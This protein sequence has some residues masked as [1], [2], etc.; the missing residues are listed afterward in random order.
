RHYARLAFSLETKTRTKWGARL[1]WKGKI[2][3]RTR[4]NAATGKGECHST[5]RKGHSK[6]SS[7]HLQQSKPMR[8]QF[9]ENHREEFPVRRMCKVLAVS[10]GGYYAWRQRPV[11]ELK[12]ANEKLVEQIR[13]I[14][15]EFKGKYGSP[16]IHQELRDEKKI[17]CSENRVARLMRENGIQAVHKRR[18]RVTTKSNPAHPTE[19]N[20]LDR[21]FTAE[22]PNQKWTSDITYIRTKEGWLYLAVVLDLF[23]RRIVGWAMS[24]RI[25]SDL[26]VD[27]LKM[28][29]QQRKPEAGL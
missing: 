14:H 3:A 12:M 19:P 18:F 20:L 25:T 24:K 21:E 29:V 16:R 17:R 13:E 4:K 2:D 10:P 11:S 28:A 5:S 7:G 15:A 1:S 26:V 27:A 22:K 9:I 8:Y 23:S 6:K